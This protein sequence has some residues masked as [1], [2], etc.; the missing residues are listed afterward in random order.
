MNL[1]SNEG[2]GLGTCESLMAGTP[3]IVNVTGGMQD[4]CGFRINDELITAKDYGE[5][6]SLHDW[7][8]W[9]HNEEL[10]WGEWAKP[11]WPRT[12]SLMGSVPT[13][14][15]MDD[16]CD[17]EDAADKLKEWFEMGKDERTKCGLKGHEFVTSDDSN[18]SARAMCGLFID[19]METAFEKWTPR[20]K[21]N[22]YK[23]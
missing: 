6:K 23:A 8:K 20:K 10:T 2:F 11:V 14:Y 9:E 5:I 13:P 4:Q 15:I 18:M 21:I 22:V 3:I 12:R 19:H 16:R 7:K 1:A 17:W